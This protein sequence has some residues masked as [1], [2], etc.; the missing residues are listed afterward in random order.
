MVYEHLNFVPISAEPL[1]E[2][3]ANSPQFYNNNAKHIKADTALQGV[4]P[5]R[6]KTL[7][8]W[9]HS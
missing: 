2:S 7:A 5:H 1:W 3:S 8:E 9:Q 6:E 4:F